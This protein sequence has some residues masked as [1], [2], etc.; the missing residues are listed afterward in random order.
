MKAP[1]HTHHERGATIVE[2]ALALLVFLMFLF[3]IM[4][5]SRMLFTWVA[6]NEAA[7]AGARYAAVCDDTSQQAKVLARMQALLPQVSSINVSWAPTGCTAASC[8]S[9]TVAITGL[10]FQWISPIAG[11][12]LQ[13]AIPMPGFSSTL[14]REVMRQDINSSTACS[15]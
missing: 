9:V 5:F 11:Q 14:P 6:A 4:D 8:Q 13:A 12:G 15:S 3:G 10:K 1:S 7:R 2:F